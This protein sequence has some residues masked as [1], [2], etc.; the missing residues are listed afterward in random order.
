M[1]DHSFLQFFLNG[2]VG[3][4]D[5]RFNLGFQPSDSFL[6]CVQLLLQC[7][8]FPLQLLKALLKLLVLTEFFKV[9]V[10]VE[11]RQPWLLNWG[12][13]KLTHLALQQA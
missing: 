11:F 6:R 12:S 9:V 1:N 2:L 3:G 5:C 8:V 13:L 7:D 10:F 4:L